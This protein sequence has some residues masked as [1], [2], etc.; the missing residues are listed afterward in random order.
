[1]HAW[2]R[3]DGVGVACVGLDEAAAFDDSTL[4][5]RPL[6]FNERANYT[7]KPL[8]WSGCCG[9]DARNNHLAQAVN[10]NRMCGAVEANIAQ[11][12][13]GTTKSP[14]LDT[15]DKSYENMLTS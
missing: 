1:M 9:R 12:I 8:L 15:I 6:S 3:G 2:G 7:A 13:G 11:H 10:Y 5:K 14:M 4:V